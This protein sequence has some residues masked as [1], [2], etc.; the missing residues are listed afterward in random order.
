MREDLCARGPKDSPILIVGDSLPEKERT[1]DKLKEILDRRGVTYNSIIVPLKYYMNEFLIEKYKLKLPSDLNNKGDIFRF[2]NAVNNYDNK[3]GLNPLNINYTSV[4]KNLRE[5]IFDSNNKVK[6]RLILCLGDFSYFAVRSL[7]KKYNERENKFYRKSGTKYTI[8]RL[9][10]YFQQSIDKHENILI[11]PILHNSTNL[12][13]SLT[14][15]FIPKDKRNIYVSYLSYIAE[16]ISRIII[17]D[18][19]MKK[20]LKDIYR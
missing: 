15:D 13:F 4:V 18:I 16:E 19:E 10:K 1:Q 7:F 5:E 14:Q 3:W 8:E 11:L 20:Y 6:Y 12:H 17:S 9:G 2:V